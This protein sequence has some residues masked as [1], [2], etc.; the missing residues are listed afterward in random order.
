MTGGPAARVCSPGVVV[1]DAFCTPDGEQWL[2]VKTLAHSSRWIPFEPPDPA[3]FAYP[4]EASGRLA[5]T[6]RWA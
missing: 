5:A 6:P 1:G 2:P 4:A 3:V